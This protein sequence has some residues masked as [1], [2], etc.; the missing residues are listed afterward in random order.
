M[1]RYILYYLILGIIAMSIS[2]CEKVDPEPYQNVPTIQEVELSLDYIHSSGVNFNI[3]IIL[4]KYY[5]ETIDVEINDGVTAKLATLRHSFDNT[6]YGSY[7]VSIDGFS[8][9][10]EL[11]Y[12]MLDDI[13]VSIKTRDGSNKILSTY[14]V[15]D[16]KYELPTIRS[17]KGGKATLYS[18]YLDVQISVELDRDFGRYIYAKVETA[19]ANFNFVSLTNGGNNVYSGTTSYT[20]SETDI[21]YDEGRIK[22]NFDVTVATGYPYC[23]LSANTYSVRN[24]TYNFT[25]PSITVLSAKK[26]NT[27]YDSSEGRYNT[28]YE[29]SYRIDGSVFLSEAYTYNL[30]NWSSNSYGKFYTLSLIEGQKTYNASILY[31][32]ESMWK[33]YVQFRAITKS[34]TL[35]IADKMVCLEAIGSGDVKVYLVNSSSVYSTRTD[36]GNGTAKAVES[37]DAQLLIDLNDDI[38]IPFAR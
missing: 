1:K 17:V 11:G 2:S 37:T 25:N 26:V 14:R 28:S 24:L 32:Y 7:G 3:R 20:F 13:D 12:M 30:G 35:L 38:E 31:D 27:N 22:C 36:C 4:D 5:G 19:S 16:I 10:R 6:Y 21:N 8:V 15:K 9:D 23:K 34:G 33:C 29:V 18:S